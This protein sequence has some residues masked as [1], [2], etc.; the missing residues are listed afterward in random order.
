[1]HY[2]RPIVT[3]A[4]G[5]ALLLWPAR[6][7]SPL[8]AEAPPPAAAVHVET[9]LIKVPE[10]FVGRTRSPKTRRPRISSANQLASGTTA[11]TK[12]PE[13]IAARAGRFVMGDGRHRPEP[14]PRPNR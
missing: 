8:G 9:Q 7:D 4:V 2:S 10:R 3:A 11:E 6:A 5:A 14:F 13:S 1:V 12:A